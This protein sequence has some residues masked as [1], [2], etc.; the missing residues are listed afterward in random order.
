MSK[1]KNKKVNPIYPRHIHNAMICATVANH[2]PEEERLQS[3]LLFVGIDM[4]ESAAKDLN[5]KMAV[6][7]GMSYREKMLIDNIT[8]SSG[9]YVRQIHKKCNIETQECFAEIAEELQTLI[10]SYLKN[11]F[12]RVPLMGR[13]E[14][15]N[16]L[17]G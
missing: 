15:N 13:K 16:E 11:N 17:A 5:D 12:H 7:G 10:R 3:W 9:A 2:D 14:D 8:K 4:I 6:V 1:K